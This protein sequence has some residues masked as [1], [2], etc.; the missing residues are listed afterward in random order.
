VDD[1]VRF[2]DSL[3]GTAHGL[4]ALASPSLDPLF[5]PPGQPGPPSAWWPHVPFGHWVVCAAQPRV[6]VD[7]G[8]GDGVAYGAFCQAV[9]QA[10]LNTRCY[11]VQPWHDA[12][13]AGAPGE[14]AFE[15]P[16]GSP[17]PRYSA[18]STPLRGTPEAALERFADRS[19]DFLH[20]DTGSPHAALRHGLESW[21]P[22]LSDRAVVLLHNPGGPGGDAGRVW[23]GL[24]E[25]FPGFEFLH[26]RGLGVLAVGEDVPPGIAALCGLA[27]PLLVAALR[28]RFAALGER[29]AGATRERILEEKL[30]QSGTAAGD[31]TGP[32]RQEARAWEMRAREAAR[33]REQIA[34]R[35]YAARHDVYDANLRAE[36]AAEEVAAANLRAVQAEEAAAAANLRA[37]QAEEAA[38]AANLRAAQA[39][40]AA[41]AA[42]LRAA[43]AEAAATAANLRAAQAEEAASL[44]AAQAEQVRIELAYAVQE[45]D[46]LLSSTTWRMTWPL[47]AAGE[48]MPPRWRRALRAGASF[49]WRSLTLT[50]RRIL[51]ER[52]ERP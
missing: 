3:A 7:L 4:D 12:P 20:I 23:A 33:A 52:G 26:G 31:E 30:A 42:N 2:P 24:R 21:E 43:Q 9:V 37:V 27:D 48:T 46:R 13:H 18:F 10:P 14:A 16:G 1:A 22:K 11:A 34:R 17:H 40:A 51:P 5:W 35:I 45:R 47:R 6:L 15:P 50:L 49:V 36:Q 32:A 25:R 39:E 44:R 41:T 19:V 38:T 8:S 28:S 29:W